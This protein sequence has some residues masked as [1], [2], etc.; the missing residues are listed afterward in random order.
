LPSDHVKNGGKGLL[1]R[2][3]EML[4]EKSWRG[5]II[6]GH[7]K[8]KTRKEEIC[9]GTPMPKHRKKKIQRGGVTEK[10]CAQGG[11]LCF[12]VKNVRKFLIGKRS[13]HYNKKK[14]KPVMTLKA[15]SVRRGGRPHR[16]L[17]S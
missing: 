8:N 13:W 10:V 5:G 1:D 16:L 3:A 15:V 14:R 9:Y 2:R 17:G 12:R 11:G 6:R 4:R 7:K